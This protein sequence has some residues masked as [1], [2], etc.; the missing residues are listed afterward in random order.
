MGAWS[1]DSRTNVATMD[2]D[3]FF[4]NEKSVVIPEDGTIR[5]WGATYGGA[6]DAGAGAA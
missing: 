1:S 6:E 3:A 4:H 2:S 5:I